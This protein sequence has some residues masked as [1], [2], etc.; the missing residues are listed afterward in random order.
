[1]PQIY[2]SVDK[3]DWGKHL[4]FTEFCYNSTTH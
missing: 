2:V 1:M 4:S 3:K